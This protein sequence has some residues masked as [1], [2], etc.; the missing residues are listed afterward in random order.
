MHQE[1]ALACIDVDAAPPCVERSALP[2]TGI[3][4]SVIAKTDWFTMSCI[5]S[6]GGVWTRP[7]TRR[8][9]VLMCVMGEAR[10]GDVV[11]PRGR[12]GLVPAC[13]GEVSVEVAPNT[14][15]V[16]AAPEKVSDPDSQ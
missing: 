15:L 1:Q 5:A 6:A 7:D 4:E 3:D 10:I 11:L 14:V 2:E 12:T 8:P 13:A 16:H 9:S